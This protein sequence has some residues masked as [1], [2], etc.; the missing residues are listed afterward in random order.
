MSQSGLK[1]P[2]TTEAEIRAIRAR[3][4]QM[5]AELRLEGAPESFIERVATDETAAKML[6]N[7]RK[8]VGVIQSLMSAA[9]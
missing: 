4:N 5:E 9:R 1:L 3:R 8:M 2:T 7:E 6:A